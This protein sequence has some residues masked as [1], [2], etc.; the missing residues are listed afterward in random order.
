MSTNDLIGKPCGRLTVLSKLPTSA[1]GHAMVLCRCE[2]GTEKPIRAEAI[3]KERIRSCGC[4]FADTHT[5]HGRSKRSESNCIFRSW[6]GM[7][8][9]CYKTDHNSYQNYGGRGITV[10]ERWLNSFEAF[11]QD[12]GERPSIKHTLDRI[13]NDGNYEPG[14]CRWATPEEQ[15]NNR[16]D[17]RFLTHDGKTQTAAQWAREVG[18][19]YITF[20]ARLRKWSVEKAITTPISEAHRRCR[21]SQ[22]HNETKH[23]S[24]PGEAT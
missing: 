2:C 14:N 4:L 15:H 10:C 19:P 20:M 13:D 16:R 23:G 17:S 3:R 5:T 24:R 6:E 8:A 9:R 21:K 22:Q 11:L 1:S 7:K 12:M 18:I